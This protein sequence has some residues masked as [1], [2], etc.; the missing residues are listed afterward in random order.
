MK[1]LKR[2]IKRQQSNDAPQTSDWQWT[3]S[4]ESGTEELRSNGAPGQNVQELPMIFGVVFVG[5]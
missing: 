3:R 4:R 5:L 1:A 2:W